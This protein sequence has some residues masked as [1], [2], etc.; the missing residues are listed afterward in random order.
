MST[1]LPADLAGYQH[2][3]PW[4]RIEHGD[5]L[6]DAGVPSSNCYETVGVLVGAVEENTPYRVYRKMPVAHQH[7]PL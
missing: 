7:D 1:T 2:L 4:V 3:E 5:I 6:V